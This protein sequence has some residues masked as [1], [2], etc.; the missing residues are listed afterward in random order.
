M[1]KDRAAGWGDTE[2]RGAGVCSASHQAVLSGA[3]AKNLL[4]TPPASCAYRAQAPISPLAPGATHGSRE[5]PSVS[6]AGP[7]SDIQTQASQAH[8]TLS[9]EPTTSQAMESLIMSAPSLCQGRRKLPCC[10]T[11]SRSQGLLTLGG[12]GRHRAQQRGVSWGPRQDPAPTGPEYRL[13]GQALRMRDN[14]SCRVSL[15][16]PRC[17]AVGPMPLG[18]IVKASYRRD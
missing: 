12:K 5:G 11:P 10:D 3:Q 9:L 14:V 8:P 17:P 18:V 6:E 13:T 7:A 4:P 2:A 16:R 1:P 15:A